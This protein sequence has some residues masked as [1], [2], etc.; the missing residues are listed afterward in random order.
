L[1]VSAIS[2]AS[3]NLLQRIGA[4]PRLNVERICG[5]TDMEV[6]D[7]GGHGNIH[8]D[9]H[10][11]HEPALGYL[12]ENRLLQFGLYETALSMNN[13]VWFAP[14]SLQQF[15]VDQR[16]VIITLASGEVLLASLLVGADGAQS[17]VR[18]RSGIAERV[19]DYQQQGLV[20]TVKTQLPHDHTARQRFLPDGIL[21]FLPLA[22]GGCSIVWSSAE[23][24][25]LLALDD[26][27]FCQ[28]LGEA[29]EYR[30]GD[31]VSV[32]PRAA[33]PLRGMQAEHY[34]QPRIALVGD[35]AHNIHPL[36]GQGVN[37]GF[38]DVAVLAELLLSA[39]RDIG[40]LH[41]LRKYERARRG[42]NEVMLR[43]MEGFKFLFNNRSP[44]LS[45][46]RNTGLSMAN[47]FT[48]LKQLT[49][50]QAMGYLD[51]APALVRPLPVE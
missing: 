46:M 25:R 37:L 10:E 11:S 27:A 34:V 5:F 31:I 21:A 43:A 15:V 12:L 3:R 36:A 32:G 4:W 41:L 20:A 13:V 23:S 19:T 14:D 18:K 17:Q 48:P 38:L 40:S 22:D 1:R 2:P 45:W 9:S 50:R 30:L 16:E 29:F 49:M 6:W 28:E 47:R 24:E 33:F 26:A 44:L 7:A 8:F 35:A 51:D 39:K 42:E